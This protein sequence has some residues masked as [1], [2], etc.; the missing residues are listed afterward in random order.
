MRRVEWNS[1]LDRLGRRGGR[2]LVGLLVLVAFPTT[3]AAQQDRLAR[4]REAYSAEAMVRIESIVTG[5]R[6]AGVPIGPIYNKALEGA[7]KGVPANLVVPALSEFAGRMGRARELLGPTAQ[8]P[9]V[10]AGADALRR[11]VAP[12]LVATIGRD[13]ANRAPIA[14]LMVG[15]LVEAG[16]PPDRALEVLR[17]ALSRTRGEDEL[18]DVPATIRRLV[19]QGSRPRD[20]ARDVLNAIRRGTPLRRL[21]RR[22]PRLDIL[23]HRPRPVPPGSRPARDKRRAPSQRGS[24]GGRRPGGG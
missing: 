8:A 16:V 10:V 5:A 21:H 23:T 12:E 15:D 1:M 13:A 7:A 22:P 2:V 19:R 18:R 24:D 11:G 4:L 3:A 20:A 14:L 17:E 6:Q 9:W